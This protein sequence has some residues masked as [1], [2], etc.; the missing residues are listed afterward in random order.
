M[1]TPPAPGNPARS[2]ERRSPAMTR[3]GGVALGLRSGRQLAGTSGALSSTDQAE[4]SDDSLAAGES[5][6]SSVRNCGSTCGHGSV[7]L[8]CRADATASEARRGSLRV[9]RRVPFLDRA[10]GPVMSRFR[11]PST[12]H[13][14]CSRGRGERENPRGSGMVRTAGRAGALGQPD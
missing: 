10:S 6:R 13:Q 2:V 3:D 9:P 12:H 7:N 14:G 1:T 5:A 4:R 11:G 8:G